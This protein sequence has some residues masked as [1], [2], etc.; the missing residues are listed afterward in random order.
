MGGICAQILPILLAV[1]FN[2]EI[3]TWKRFLNG[4][5]YSTTIRV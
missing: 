2:T 3:H 5:K 1:I 4:L